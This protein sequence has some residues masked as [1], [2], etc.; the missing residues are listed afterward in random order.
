MIPVSVEVGWF[1]I[2]ELPLAGDLTPGERCY[3]V[4]LLGRPSVRCL[5]QHG[6]GREKNCLENT[7]IPN[8]HSATLEFQRGGAAGVTLPASTVLLWQEGRW[9]GRVL[10]HNFSFPGAARVRRGEVRWK[11]SCLWPA[12]CLPLVSQPWRS[13]RLGRLS[14][15]AAGRA[16]RST[17]GSPVCVTGSLPVRWLVLPHA[18]G[19]RS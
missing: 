10:P 3:A 13:G 14:P 17:P 12:A 5:K 8:F 7:F 4:T 9:V 11:R 1:C 2:G 18:G 16:A 19:S 6:E 15:A